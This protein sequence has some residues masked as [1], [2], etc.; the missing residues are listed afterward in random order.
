MDQDDPEKRIAELENQLAEQKRVA[1][2]ERQIAEAP[3]PPQWS[4]TPPSPP[5]APTGQAIGFRG[6]WVSVDGGGFQQVGGPGAALPPQ[7]AEQLAGLIRQVVRQ[8]EYSGPPGPVSIGGIG[9]QPVLPEAAGFGAQGGFGYQ[10]P[11][12]KVSGIPRKFIVLGFAAFFMVV[13]LPTLLGLSLVGAMLLVATT[14]SS[15]GWMSDLVC[16]SGDELTANVSYYGS[17]S[18]SWNTITFQCVDGANAYD[19]SNWAI[20]GFQT[21]AIALVALTLLLCIALVV[22]L[23]FRT[24]SPDNAIHAVFTVLTCGLWAPVWMIDAIFRRR[25]SGAGIAIT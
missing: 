22:W 10:S 3:P 15:V 17:Q 7:A 6:A 19:A 23:P 5:S 13:A 14:P 1:E 24:S 21:A 20:A 12:R 11:R 9:S 8:A 16:N 18:H 25:G 2:P 4:V